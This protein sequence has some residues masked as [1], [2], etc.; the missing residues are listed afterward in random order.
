MIS[1]NAKNVILTLKESQ[2]N[3]QEMILPA[4]SHNYPCSYKYLCEIVFLTE[5]YSYNIKKM[6]NV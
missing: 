5:K 3:I 1:L 2:T 4:S 6:N